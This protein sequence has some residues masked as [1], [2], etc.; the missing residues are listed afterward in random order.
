MTERGFDGLLHSLDLRAGKSADQVALLAVLQC[1]RGADGNPI[2]IQH[3]LP[4]ILIEEGHSIQAQG[5][6]QE[7]SRS[8]RLINDADDGIGTRDSDGASFGAA[9]H[10]LQQRADVRGELNGGIQVG[11]YGLG[12][13]MGY[14]KSIRAAAL[15]QD[16]F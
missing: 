10:A 12:R 11:G 3:E 6:P 8:F 14:R 16:R 7:I 13:K 2:T 1:L 15:Q 5:F 9:S 4:A